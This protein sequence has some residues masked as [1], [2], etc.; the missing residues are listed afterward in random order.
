MKKKILQHKVIII[1][2][3][4]GV[5]HRL[6]FALLFNHMFDFGSILAL[7]KSVADTGDITAGFIVLKNNNILS[8]FFGKLFYQLG[9][10]WLYFLQFM[11]ILDIR[12]IFDIKP[13]QNIESY[14]VGFNAWN[15]PL[16]QLIAIKLSQFFYDFIF[17]FFL[18]KIAKLIDIKKISLIFLFW[19]INPF[20]VFVSYAMY[21]SD[22]LMLVFFMGGVYFALRS[23]TDISNKNLK[24]KILAILF[25]SAG[26]VIKQVPIL[27]IPFIIIIFS[28]SFLSFIGYAVIFIFFYQFLSQPWSMDYVLQRT[29]FLSSRE[30]LAIF[31]FQLNGVSI[32]LFI[33]LSI[34]FFIL[35]RRELII[36]KPFNLLIL[37]TLTLCGLYI[38]ENPELL[39]VN[40]NTWIMPFI[41]LIALKDPKYSLLLFAPIIGFFKRNLIDNTFLS[42]ALSETL[43]PSFIG[44]PSY[45]KLLQYTISPVLVGLLLNSIMIVI[46]IIYSIVLILDLI[47]KKVQFIGEMFLVQNYKKLIFVLFMSFYLIFGI[48]YL[49][50]TNYTSIKSEPIQILDE[51]T[52]LRNNTIKFEIQNPNSFQLTALELSGRVTK[53]NNI[54]Y[55][56]VRLSDNS[57]ILSEQR[58]MDYQLPDTPGEMLIFFNK[59]VTNKKIKVEIYKLR[60]NNDVEIQEM[61]KIDQ[62]ADSGKFNLDGNI[63]IKFSS[64]PLYVK[65]YRRIDYRT[66]T[67]TLAKHLN[68]KPKFFTA[69]SLILTFLTFFILILNKIKSS[70]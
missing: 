66:V 49:I 13:Y 28:Q 21:Q 53:V 54:D 23:L 4:V 62:T 38:S 47:G 29:F 39:Y 36:K 10:L 34:L 42:G 40:F 41:I 70:N 17:L 19:A 50:K 58:V 30:S 46:Y 8:Q 7:I 64:N 44:S 51:R 18:V 25:F 43:G 3:L 65:L 16:Y 27:V 52:I 26:A 57:Q 48:D 14:M 2:I 9:A 11:H 32:F 63:K 5:I 60:K 1:I 56:V 35:N 12:Y 69:F 22:L 45:L 37:I 33:Y 59:A 55:L 20:M 67:Q 68:S 24:F 15:P 31:N 6:I 61:K